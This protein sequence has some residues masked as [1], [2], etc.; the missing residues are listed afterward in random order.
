[1]DYFAA[2]LFFFFFRKNKSCKER[3]HGASQF[4]GHVSSLGSLFLC[5]R[6]WR[7]LPEKVQ[8]LQLAAVTWAP[9]QMKT[10]L[11]RNATHNPEVL[12][13]ISREGERERE[14]SEWP[15]EGI[16]LPGLCY[17]TVGVYFRF[18]FCAVKMWKPDSVSLKKH[19]HFKQVEKSH[20]IPSNVQ[21]K[22]PR[23]HCSALHL[24]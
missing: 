19:N 8:G 20:L 4:P 21:T 24:K 6:E 16:E 13:V 11:S 2:W 23:R 15:W 10:H 12:L 14:R 18:L 1:M 17:W 9:A 3:E 7:E 5:F 22:A